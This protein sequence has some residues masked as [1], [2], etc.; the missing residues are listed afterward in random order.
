MHL[1]RWRQL[2]KDLGTAARATTPALL[3]P[4][5]YIFRINYC[6]SQVDLYLLNMQCLAVGN[7]V[8][9]S[10]LGHLFVWSVVNVFMFLLLCM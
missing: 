5:C 8:S 3:I 6:W 4:G 10:F 2:P 9:K 7:S 1:E